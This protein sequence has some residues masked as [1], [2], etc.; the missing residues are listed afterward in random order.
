VQ[1]PSKGGER[2]LH[3]PP[4]SSQYPGAAGSSSP[5]PSSLRPVVHKRGSRRSNQHE[6][7][8]LSR[9]TVLELQ[10]CGSPSLA[11]RTPPKFGNRR[12]TRSTHL[13]RPRDRG[14]Q[15]FAPLFCSIDGSCYQDQARHK[16]TIFTQVQDAGSE[17]PTSCMSDFLD[18]A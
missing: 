3:P 5:P 2:T 18:S 7:H 13:S 10:L 12:R 1:P 9:P 11:N 15:G 6:E 17:T 8:T 4:G 16:S 14:H